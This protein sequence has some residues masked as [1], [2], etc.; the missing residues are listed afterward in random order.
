MYVSLC[1]SVFGCM[2]ECVSAC[3]HKFMCECTRVSLSM[4]LSSCI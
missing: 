3:V 2:C 4:S 1:V